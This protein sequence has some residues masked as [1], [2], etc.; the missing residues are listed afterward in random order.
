MLNT[1]L[2]ETCGIRLRALPVEFKLS[3]LLNL[4]TSGSYVNAHC[5]LSISFSHSIKYVTVTSLSSAENFCVCEG[6]KFEVAVTVRPSSSAVVGAS[7]VGSTVVGSTVVGSTVVSTASVVVGT[8][9]AS[10]T[11]IL[12]VAPDFEA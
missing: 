5:E 3:E 11:S 2:A 10:T 7:V 6:K 1:P 8:S 4:R 9:K 12:N